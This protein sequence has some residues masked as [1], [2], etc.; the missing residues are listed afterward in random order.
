MTQMWVRTPCSTADAACSI[1]FVQ[2]LQKEVNALYDIF[3]K[4]VTQS[5]YM[6]RTP[7]LVDSRM[8]RRLWVVK[9]W[10]TGFCVVVFV[11]RDSQHRTIQLFPCSLQRLCLAPCFFCCV[12]Q[13]SIHLYSMS[14]SCCVSERLLSESPHQLAFALQ[15]RSQH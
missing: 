4:S 9:G 15:H 8:A 1:F 14:Q 3:M 11:S 5:V 7:L 6:F 12:L 2:S 13:P 10:Q